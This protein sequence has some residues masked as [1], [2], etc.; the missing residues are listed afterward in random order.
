M[1]V[2]NFAHLKKNKAEV[3][4]SGEIEI[5]DRV[6]ASRTFFRTPA[7]AETALIV[8]VNYCRPGC[9][10]FL[11]D[12][13]GDTEGRYGYCLREDGKYR[14]IPSSAVVGRCVYK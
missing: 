13:R 5:R 2:L 4:Q 1:A 3:P 7:V 6:A 14:A 8:A 10:R 9:D 11:P 12:D